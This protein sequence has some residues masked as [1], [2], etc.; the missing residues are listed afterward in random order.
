MEKIVKRFDIYPVRVLEIRNR[1][2]EW[3]DSIWRHD[4]SQ[5]SRTVQRC[6]PLDP[7]T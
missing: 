6:E 5:F 4:S 2:H 3:E 1:I 7:E